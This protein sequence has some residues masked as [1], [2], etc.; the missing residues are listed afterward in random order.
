MEVDEMNIKHKVNK[1]NGWQRLWLFFCLI[2]LVG[3]CAINI[4]NIASYF[5]TDSNYFDENLLL[6]NRYKI[7]KTS[8]KPSKV[9]EEFKIYT[10]QDS[11]TGK[12]VTFLWYELYPPNDSDM[13]KIFQKAK[14]LPIENITHSVEQQEKTGFAKNQLSTFIQQFIWFSIKLLFFWTIA[15][16]FLYFTGIIINWIIIGFRSPK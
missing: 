7:I 5:K 2:T 15:C 4:F 9:A 1:L 10:V 6:A 12:K 13:A 8:I 16:A 14:T 3:I 11:K